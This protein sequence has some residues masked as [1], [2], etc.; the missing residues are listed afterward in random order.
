VI[1]ELIKYLVQ[2]IQSQIKKPIFSV[3][4]E[5]HL[6]L[7]ELNKIENYSEIPEEID[8][9]IGYIQLAFD[10]IERDS[11]LQILR[12]ELAADPRIRKLQNL[13]STPIPGAEICLGTEVIRSILWRYLNITKNLSWNQT[14]L[15]GI[16]RESEQTLDRGYLH[17][18]LVLP[19]L[20]LSG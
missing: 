3:F 6:L 17:V 7:W 5:T 9:M 14:I 12:K 20:G 4:D 15:E 19:L 8:K 1:V 10:E 16:L 18:D 11:R 13:N 2:I